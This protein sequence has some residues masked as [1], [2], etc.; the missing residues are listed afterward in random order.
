[1]RSHPSIALVAGCLV[2]LLARGLKQI[3]SEESPAC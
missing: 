1:M 2:T 3:A